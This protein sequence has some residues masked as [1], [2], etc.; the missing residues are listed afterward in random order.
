MIIR[1]K[2]DRGVLVACAEMPTVDPFAWY[3]ALKPIVCFSC[4]GW[5]AVGARIVCFSL[6]KVRSYAC[7]FRYITSWQITSYIVHFTS[8][9]ASGIV[10]WI[11][12][13][14][15]LGVV[16][17]AVVYELLSSEQGYQSIFGGTRDARYVHSC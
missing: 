7:G 15:A 12:S 4:C 14:E 16:V 9:R 10:R 11:D 8:L 5:S 13:E 2:G 1:S 6:G 3:V 17:V